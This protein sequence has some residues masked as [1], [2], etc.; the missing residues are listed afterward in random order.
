MKIVNL[1]NIYHVVVLDANRNHIQEAVE[2]ENTEEIKKEIEK[3]FPDY[4]YM[5]IRH[6]YE[7][8]RP[9]VEVGKWC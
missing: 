6:V 9:F 4:V 2:A 3:R 7:N 8:E 1:N 5:A